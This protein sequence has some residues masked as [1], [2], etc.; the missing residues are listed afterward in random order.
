LPVQPGEPADSIADIEL[1][2]KELGFSPRWSIQEKL[3]EV[4][5]WNTKNQAL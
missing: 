2:K 3:P 4:I 1:A 5:E